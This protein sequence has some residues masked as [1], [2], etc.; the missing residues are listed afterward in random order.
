MTLLFLVVVDPDE[1]LLF[2]RLLFLLLLA[3]L[4]LIVGWWLYC[5]PSNMDGIDV[6]Q[7]AMPSKDSFSTEARFSMFWPFVRMTLMLR[8]ELGLLL[9]LWPQLTLGVRRHHRG[10]AFC[11]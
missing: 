5:H 7:C 3:R 11:V 2:D 8:R 1:G 10:A 6:V 4:V 9:I